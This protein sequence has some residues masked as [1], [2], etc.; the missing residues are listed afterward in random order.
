MKKPTAPVLCY[1]L[2]LS[3]LAMSSVQVSAQEVTRHETRS[4]VLEF[5][6]SGYPTAETV[7]HIQTE[8]DYQRAVQAYIHWIPAVGIMQWRNAH[9][10]LGGKARDLIVY[11]TTE[12]KQPILTGNDTTS[13]ILSFAE[14]ADTDGLLIM[15]VPPGPT[16]GV[17]NDL[18]QR[19]VTDLGMTGPEQGK[20]GRFL[21]VLKGT[22]VPENHGADYVV[23]SE[24]STILL[25][26]RI[27]TPDPEE[28]EKL[29]AA[30]KIR[31]LGKASET[32]VI[33]ASHGNWEGWHPRGLDYWKVVHQAIQLNSTNER[34]LFMMQGLKNLGIER[35]KPFE[36]TPEQIEILEQAALAGETWAMA[37]SFSKRKP[38]KH[39]DIL[40]SQWQYIL[41]MK[42]PLTQETDDY[43]EIDARSAF[44]YEAIT[45]AEGNTLEI[46][47]AGIQ[48]LASYKDD[49]GLWLDGAKS[50]ELLVP[51]DVPAL[52]FWSIVLYG[53]DTR[54]ML[55]NPQGQAEINSRM[56]LEYNDD[57]SLLLTFS[58]NRPDSAESN[59]TQTNPEKG[60]F[61]YFRWYA[62]TKEFFDRSW[63]MGNIKEV[64]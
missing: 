36:P 64:K 28:G 5:D 30:H 21:I 22:T 7:R 58:P 63:V 2:G 48:Y 27:L 10:E 23:T 11:S 6:R 3:V 47:D 25:G 24:T 33:Q 43:G 1:V 38:V 13:Y 15:E 14:L 59:W 53:N 35:G 45:I 62:P 32:Q 51:P 26:T 40:G 29:L 39:W 31:P 41:F 9:F 37:N 60:F 18:W 19:P 12:T 16:G 8:I 34:D 52:N 17:I 49:N 46:V 55:V 20:G 61:A 56:D 44:A 57:G 4:G 50:Y 54:A 42:N